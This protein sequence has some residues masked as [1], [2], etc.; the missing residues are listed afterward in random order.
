MTEVT[1]ADLARDI[2]AA[3]TAHH[4]SYDVQR[5]RHALPLYAACRAHC[6]NETLTI[7]HVALAASWRDTTQW[8]RDTLDNMVTAVDSDARQHTP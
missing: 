1:I 8:A 7:A 4:A 2:L 6:R 5:K 3:A